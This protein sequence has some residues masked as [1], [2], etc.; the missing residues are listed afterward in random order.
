[1]TIMLILVSLILIIKIK[2]KDMIKLVSIKK[3]TNEIV[4]GVQSSECG[5]KNTFLQ[6]PHLRVL[7]TKLFIFIHLNKEENR[8][9][10]D[11]DN[12]D[13]DAMK[14]AENVFT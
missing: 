8:H 7:G 10:F 4:R 1:M 2:E 14:I 9:E 3:I 5:R 6:L 13:D 12:G 11:H